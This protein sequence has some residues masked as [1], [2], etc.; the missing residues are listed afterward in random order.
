MDF[1]VFKQG[2]E[3]CAALTQMI[4]DSK[5]RASLSRISDAVKLGLSLSATGIQQDGGNN[6]S[7]YMGVCGHCLGN[8][9][10]QCCAACRQIESQARKTF[11]VFQESS[12][13]CGLTE[14]DDIF[15]TAAV[16]L[17]FMKL[18]HGWENSDWTEDILK[19][20]EPDILRRVFEELDDTFNIKLVGLNLQ[21]ILK[22]SMMSIGINGV[23]VWSPTLI[24]NIFEDRLSAIMSS[25]ESPSTP[26]QCPKE[27]EIDMFS[28]PEE[29]D[30]NLLFDDSSEPTIDMIDADITCATLQHLTQDEGNQEYK[31]NQY[32][33][34]QQRGL[35]T[36]DS[37]FSYDNKCSERVLVDQNTLKPRT[38]IFKQMQRTKQYRNFIKNTILLPVK[39][40]FKDPMHCAFLD[41]FLQIEFE[42][43]FDTSNYKPQKMISQLLYTDRFLNFIKSIVPKKT[44]SLDKAFYFVNQN[45]LMKK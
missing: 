5:S 33:S 4:S 8:I 22:K 37:G 1:V 27:N 13:D 14:R 35:A 34:K 29:V 16:I 15:L 38:T 9:R 40:R 10:G 44:D 18:H 17:D 3:R 31:E 32:D 19:R 42:F 23:H 39:K 12:R 20:I 45:L 7:E 30:V 21:T 2:R 41:N 11:I 6:S 24:K 36:C 26:P 43:K 28:F 25:D